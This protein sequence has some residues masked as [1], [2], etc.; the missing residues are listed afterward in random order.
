[1]CLNFKYQKYV[2][3]S[4]KSFRHLI[5]KL[6]RSGHSVHEVV[7]ANNVRDSWLIKLNNCNLTL[8][9]KE[10][11]EFNAVEPQIRKFDR[12]Q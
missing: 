10:C 8:L 7:A 12:R 1:M 6:A 11:Q 5:P 3:N 2:K 9:L 4:Q